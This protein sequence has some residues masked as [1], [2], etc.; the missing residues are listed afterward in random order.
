MCQECNVFSPDSSAGWTLVNLHS[1][2]LPPPPPPWEENTFERVHPH[3][4]SLVKIWI[5]VLFVL[6]LC[7]GQWDEQDSDISNVAHILLKFQ[8]NFSA[9]I[10]WLIVWNGFQFI[11]ETSSLFTSSCGNKSLGNKSPARPQKKWGYSQYPRVKG[12]SF[13]IFPKEK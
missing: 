9:E 11:W 12:N 1:L 4:F 13:Q 6:L 3:R 5:V 7:F 2:L 10:D 8:N